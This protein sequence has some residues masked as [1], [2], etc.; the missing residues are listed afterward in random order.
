[1][2]SE[3]YCKQLDGFVNAIK[4]FY[5]QVCNYYDHNVPVVDCAEVRVE[6]FKL[7]YSKGEFVLNSKA[8]AF[9]A[10]DTILNILHAW[11]ICE[12]NKL[13]ITDMSKAIEVSCDP[14]Q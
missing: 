5:D 4:K 6:L 10:L 11:I 14:D 3:G 2:P 8:D 9:D 7:Y 12:Q 13:K 1:M